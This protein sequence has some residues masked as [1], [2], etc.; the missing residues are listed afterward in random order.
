[1]IAQLL[2]DNGG[3]FD[4]WEPYTPYESLTVHFG[5]HTQVVLLSWLTGM[6]A[7]TATLWGGQLIN[8]LA[9]LTIF[10]LAM[11]L[12]DGNRWA[13]TVA[14]LVA[15]L[16]SPMPSFY[17][18]WG[19]FPQ[20]AGQ[21]ML[22]IAIWM[23]WY[24]MEH[25]GWSWAGVA[26][27]VLCGMV[28][29]YYRMPFY[30]AIFVLVLFMISGIQT[31]RHEGRRWWKHIPHLAGIAILALILFAPWMAQVAGGRLTTAVAAGVNRTTP[32]AQVLAD[33]V[34]WRDIFFYVP[35]F[36][37]LSAGACLTWAILARQ[38][39]VVGIGLWTLG[40]ASLVAGRLIRLPG[41]N[42]MQN[43]AIVIALYMPVSLVVGWGA[44]RLVGLFTQ[45][46][47]PTRGMVVSMLLLV[48]A[49]WGTKT[50]LGD[51]DLSF[52]LVNRPDLRAMAWIREHTSSQAKFL[53][54][55]FRIYGGYT[56]VGADAGW[57][58]PL[59]T[60]RQNTIPPQ[61]AMFNERPIDAGH[62]QSVVARIA[63]LEE[64]PLSSREVLPLLCEAN[65]SHAYVGQGQGNVGAGVVQLFDP[66][67]LND[68]PFFE[69]TYHRDRVWIFDFDTSMCDE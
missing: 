7:V 15:G 27:I 9:A 12:S 44:G 61:Y 43:F 51:V 5:F 39:F 36:L 24:A 41:A 69:P 33:Y 60:Q 4:S 56:A 32:V 42:M 64:I 26:G 48:A 6:S 11:R 18:N 21:V 45:K 54:E 16:L 23:T 19:R 59:L 3:L 34:V 52:A 47:G 35:Q 38:S 65:I 10:P 37:L 28:L 50:R 40:L 22:P 62:T 53:V 2:V 49:L 67:D 13:G 58:I 29:T 8:G 25:H 17:V 63:V 20:L 66:Q 68:S 14:V 1:M 46:H 55:G 31:W 30:Y 57:W